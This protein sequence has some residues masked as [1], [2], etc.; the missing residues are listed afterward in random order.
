[1]SDR[2]SIALLGPSS[3]FLSGISYYTT[4]LSNALSE[5]YQVQAILFRHMLPRRLFPGASRVGESLA[6]ITYRDEVDVRE[7]MDWYNPL[8]WYRAYR[9]ASVSEVCIFEWWT[10]S[11]AH[12]YLATGLLLRL[13]GI[14]IVL[15]FHEVVDTL[16]DVIF[17]IRMYSKVMGRL[18][19][20]LAVRYVTHSISD[21]KLVAERYDIPEEQISVIPLGLFNQYKCIDKAVARRYLEIKE[22]HI[23][24]FFGLLR[25]YKGVSNL[26]HAFEQLPPERKEDTLLL[27]AGEIWEDQDVVELAKTSPDR[28]HIRLYSEYLPDDMVPYLFSAADMLVLP[29]TRASQSGVAHIGISYGM[30]IIA[31]KVGGLQESLGQYE[32]TYFVPPQ[33]V[34]ALSR[35]IQK[36]LQEEIDQYKIPPEL[37]WG[38]VQ[39]DWTTILNEVSEK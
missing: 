27:I 38:N 6:T 36:L 32:G 33:D 1:M 13:S 10:S 4:Y 30:A 18:I 34:P 5:P 19:R 21:Q 37:E 7:C 29:Y 9:A 14:P 20:R 31:S 12:M 15:E 25:P 16:E 39:K 23:I 8:T 11:V 35:A 26:I 17:P 22:S 28:E 24:L 2:K 3:R